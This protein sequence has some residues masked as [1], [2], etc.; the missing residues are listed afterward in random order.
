MDEKRQEQTGLMLIELEKYEK[1]G[2]NVLAPTTHMQ[3]I[4]PFHRIRIETVQ[5]DPDPGKRRGLQGGQQVCRKT[6]KASRYMKTS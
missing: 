1:E 4:S 5:I 2:F 6:V 3:Q